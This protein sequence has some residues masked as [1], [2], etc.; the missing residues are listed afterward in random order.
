MGKIKNIKTGIKTII[1]QTIDLKKY[2]FTLEVVEKDKVKSKQKVYT[3]AERRDINL[4]H[5][6]GIVASEFDEL[7]K[8]QNF[9]CACCGKDYTNDNKKEFV[10]DH[11]HLD[12]GERCKKKDIRGIICRN[13]NLMLGHSKDNPENLSLGS[14]Y[15][16]KNGYNGIIKKGKV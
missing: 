4:K 15:L 7:I 2:K 11:K 10:V 13:C 3:K 16:I 5:R 9:E 12:E 1:S 14:I 6:Y 8:E